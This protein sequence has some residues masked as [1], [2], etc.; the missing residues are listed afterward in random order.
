MRPILS[1]AFLILFIP[2]CAV[3]Q[4]PRRLAIRAGKLIDGKNDVPIIR[5]LILIEG[6]KIVSVTSEGTPPKDVEVIDLSNAT[7]LPGLIDTHTHLLFSALHY[8]D[9]LLKDSIPYRAILG[10][11]NSRISLENGFTTLRDLETEGAMYADVDI[12]M[13]IERGEIP[14]PRLQVATRALAP[15]GMYP[16]FGY[17]WEL[18]LRHGVQ[19][20][21]G[22]ENARLAVREQV[23]HGADWIKYYS[24]RHNYYTPDG[25]LHGQV[26]FTDEEAHAIVDEAHRLGKRVASHA[27]GLEGIA[28]ALRAG[29]DSIEHGDG[30][31]E[32]LAD[33]M[34]KMK[35]FLVPTISATAF[36]A[37]GQSVDPKRMDSKRTAFSIALK[38][39]V[40]I[41]CGSD[42]SGFSWTAFSQ[43]RELRLYVQYG[44]R[45]IQAIRSATVVA[46]ELMGWG[47]RIGSIETG[48][49][50]DLIAVSGDPLNDITELER[51]QFV[52]KG[53]VIYKQKVP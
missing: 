48:K 46:A 18:E 22:V 24:D 26:N 19:V 41:A 40:K 3:S 35:V 53:G 2:L 44:M 14:G 10:V 39:K 23:S 51:V 34:V 25:V 32:D 13:A 15:T 28:A 21:D 52:M 37:P 49:L 45:P 33:Q 50:A 36:V 43:A 47:D 11:R 20:V 1:M 30:L 9:Q 16:P 29:T 4:A 7:V 17:S 31:T 6:D 27:V 5:A 42:V 38:K 12:K 8:D